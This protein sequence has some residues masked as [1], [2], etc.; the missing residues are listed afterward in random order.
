M[1]EVEE[2]FEKS[3]DAPDGV[4]LILVYNP[5]NVAD[6]TVADLEWK[7]DK[8]LDEYLDGLPEDIEWYVSINGGV[9]PEK[10][11]WH[12]RTLNNGDA[13][14]VIPVPEGGGGGKHLLKLVAVVALAVAAPYLAGALGP[15]LGISATLAKGLAAAVVAIGG[16][17][18]NALIPP[19]KPPTPQEQS[20]S[21]TFGI[22]G[23][24]NTSQEDVPVPVVYGLHRVGGNIVQQYV[25]NGIDEDGGTIQY[26]YNQIIVSEGEIED[27]TDI[28]INDN[29]STNYTNFETEVHKG[30]AD[31]ELSQWFRNSQVGFSVGATLSDVYSVFTTQTEVDRL[32]VDLVA[33]GGLAFFDKSTGDRI[34][35]TVPITIQ[36]RQVGTTKWRNMGIETEWIENSDPDAPLDLAAPDWA[37]QANFVT[38]NNTQFQDWGMRAEYRKVGDPTWIV[39]EEKRG[40]V[41]NNKFLYNDSGSTDIEPYAV[42]ER[43]PTTITRR[44][45]LTGLEEA[46]YETRVVN[47]EPDNGDV[48]SA[49]FFYKSFK[50]VRMTDSTTSAVRRSVTSPK[51]VTGLYEVRVKR[52]PAFRERDY[53]LRVSGVDMYLNPEELDSD[54]DQV[55]DGV[56][57]NELVEIIDDPVAYNYTGW[58]GFKFLVTDQISGVPKVTALVKGKK[59]GIYDD[60]GN[61][62]SIAWS[63]NP[64][65]VA[66]DI[67]TSPRY[68]AEMAKS[69]IDFASFADWRE[70]CASDNL[71]VNI[72]FDWK[73]NI[74]EALKIV[75]RA[76][77]AMLI[78]TGTKFSVAME[79]ADDPVM[80]FGV[81]NM[82]KGSFSIEYLPSED[83]VNEIE[84]TFM[85][86][87]DKYRKK[88]IKV[89]DFDTVN[90]G[91]P[92]KVA[93]IELFGITDVNKVWREAHFQLAFNKYISRIISFDAPVESLGVNVGDVILVQHD[94]PQWGFAG[95]VSTG[96]T[97]TVVE[98]DRDVTIEA[99]R[100]YSLLV[101]HDAI[102]RYDLTFSNQVGK[103]VFVSGLPSSYSRIKRIIHNGNDYSIERVIWGS[104]LTELVLGD[105]AENVTFFGTL[106]AWDTDVVEERNVVVNTGTSS[107]VTVDSP[108]SQVPAQYSN[109]MFGEVNKSQ[110]KYRV[111]SISGTSEH[112]RTIGAME[113]IPEV[114]T[115]PTEA[116]PPSTT[117]ALET[118]NHTTDVSI[119]E[120]L[121]F[122]GSALRVRVNV[123]WEKPTSPLYE[124]AYVEARVN[125]GPWAVMDTVR[126][127]ATSGS[128]EARSGDVLSIRVVPFDG[129]GAVPSRSTAIVVDYDVLGELAPPGEVQNFVVSKTPNGIQF[130]W[131]ANTE[132][133]VVGYTI[134]QGASW[135]TG[136]TVVENY[137]GTSFLSSI[138]Q[139][140]TYTFHI[141]A[142]DA[143][144]DE[145]NLVTSSTIT[146]GGPNKVT[147]FVVAKHLDLLTFTWSLMLREIM[148]FSMKSEKAQTGQHRSSSRRL[149]VT[150]MRCL[151][152]QLA[153]ARSGLKLSTQ[154]AF[155][156]RQ[157]YLRAQQS[158]CPTLAILSLRRTSTLVVTLVQSCIQPSTLQI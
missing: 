142:V 69:R 133:D 74:W 140:G 117:G 120:Q 44:W 9:E 147:G 97:L 100:T 61:V 96:S 144:G 139:A 11:N 154:R 40:N 48:A 107:Q 65:D 87:D 126:S 115:N 53:M 38:N 146:F 14:V 116:A 35:I 49:G 33:P 91:T 45:V 12:N 6:R 99:G 106:E 8:T 130:D 73:S 157:P 23:P 76:G 84:V 105:G 37:I 83:R 30:V 112:F 132:I 135:D 72:N 103:S 134:K 145:S 19:P 24:K 27:I 108:F 52:A 77:R 71:N 102:K 4:R 101:L 1:S 13:L 41:N 93:Q 68:G 138:P 151:L 118:I 70:Y 153:L 10:E 122:S 39:L 5:L 155:I 152:A 47:L 109:F 60:E 81:G 54:S 78:S 98:L 75:F 31:E 79:K 32:R 50:P 119:T 121:F 59:V 64:A 124:G 28:E 150:I 66:L 26:L 90:I 18:I 156:V 21:P 111:R 149:A 25:E 114:Y 104:P 128:F 86:K 129:V 42:Y 7:E 143:Q 57:W 131:D 16:L 3:L 80:M 85:D 43:S 127:Q 51:L 113:Y 56:A 46:I 63:D 92:Q 36:Y 34:A 58:V 158:R 22:D 110:K 125:G 15:T 88:S 2:Q 89:V 148:W 141:K 95:R 17:V 136:T 94:M 29:P 20:D 62:T 82:V 123:T 137:A 67:M 55:I